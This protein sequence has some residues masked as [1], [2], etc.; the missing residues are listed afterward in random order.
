MM[1]QM[2]PCVMHATAIGV[3][4]REQGGTWRRPSASGFPPSHSAGQRPVHAQSLS[5]AAAL[6]P[7]GRL[8][9]L[10]RALLLRIGW[11]NIMEHNDFILYIQT[12]DSMLDIDMVEPD[13]KLVLRST[14]QA[15][16]QARNV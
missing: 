8:V 11:C 10:W 16:Q 6:S 4:G 7:Y 1:K 3:D 2:W 14:P 13:M 12:D 15:K 9:S 5:P